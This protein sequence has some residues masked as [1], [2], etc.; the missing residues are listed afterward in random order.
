MSAQRVSLHDR[1]I[2]KHFE[3]NLVKLAQLERAGH[4]KL[5]ASG[6]AF[7]ELTECIC[8]RLRLAAGK[9]GGK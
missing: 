9:A 8:E 1:R 6:Q 7:G 2:L 5:C 4:R 3:S